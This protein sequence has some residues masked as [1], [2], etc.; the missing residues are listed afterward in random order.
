MDKT[1]PCVLVNSKLFDIARNTSTSTTDAVAIKVKIVSLSVALS[2][3]SVKGM[4]SCITKLTLTQVKPS[5]NIKLK[6][7]PAID[8]VTAISPNPRLLIAIV[9]KASPTELP[10][11]RTVKPNNAADIPEMSS[12]V[13]KMSTITLANMYTQMSDIMKEDI[14]QAQNSLKGGACSFLLKK[15]IH[16]DNAPASTRTQKS[17]QLTYET[18]CLVKS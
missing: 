9:A 8:P 10:Q 7:G 18:L 14:C 2:S 13:V 3:F 4:P 16:V 12:Y 15:C 11:E 17:S 6:T 5:P 1:Y